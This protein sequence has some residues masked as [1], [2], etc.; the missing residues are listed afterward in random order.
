MYQKIRMRACSR[1]AN[2]SRRRSSFSSEA[3]KVSARALSEDDLFAVD[4]GGGLLIDHMVM[5]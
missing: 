4:F 5:R 2:L 1:V 3:K